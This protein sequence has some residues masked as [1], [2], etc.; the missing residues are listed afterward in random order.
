[1]AG[2]PR[3]RARRPPEAGGHA[4]IMLPSA[5]R[6]FLCTRPTDLR[7][8]FDGLSGLVQECFS[9]ELLTGH[10]FLF[11]NRRRDRIKILYFD[12]DGLAIWY[13]R[14]EAGSFQLPETVPR[15]GVE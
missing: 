15:D 1:M 5:V 10:L 9:Q 13:K 12:R 8:S 7:K 2:T 6:I 11:L 14:L 4:M 3:H